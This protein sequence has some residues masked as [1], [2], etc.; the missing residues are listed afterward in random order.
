MAKRAKQYEIRE[1]VSG[2]FIGAHG[3]VRYD[4]EAGS[5]SE[6]DVDREVLELLIATGYAVDPDEHTESESAVDASED[7]AP[8][9]SEESA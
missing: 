5:A 8:T 9:E 1:A 7:R 3:R 2:S 6:R 4:V